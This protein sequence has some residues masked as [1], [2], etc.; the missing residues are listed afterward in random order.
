GEVVQLGGK[1]LDRP[2]YDLHGVFVG[3]EGTLGIAT[4]IVVRVVP[5][6]ES[7]RTLVAFF[8]S[9][10]AAG[11][12]VSAIVSA[13]VVP[14]AIEMMDRLTPR[15]YVQD[16]VIPRTRLPDVLE[17]IDSLAR[18]YGL[19]VGN[20][21]HAGDGNLHPLV[22]YGEGEAERAEEL[23]GEIVL[24]CVQAGGSITGEHG[25]GVDQKRYMPKMC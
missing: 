24:A 15:Y 16:S 12:A 17:R 22:C 1:E 7:V 18:E 19:Q 8:E 11:H 25:V 21:F 2:G 5:A 3:S 23:A 4:K 10:A 13:G 9:P 20:V 14:G 6:P